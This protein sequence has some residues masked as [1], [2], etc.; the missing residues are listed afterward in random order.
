MVFGR[1]CAWFAGI[2]WAHVDAKLSTAF[3]KQKRKSMRLLRR[4]VRVENYNAARMRSAVSEFWPAIL[5]DA[6]R[7]SAPVRGA[8]RQGGFG[9]PLGVHCV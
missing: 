7:A 6:S 5:S 1:G 2:V 4:L 9:A 3:L 8:M